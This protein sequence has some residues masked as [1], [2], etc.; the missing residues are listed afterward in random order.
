MS[1]SCVLWSWNNIE[2]GGPGGVRTLAGA[3]VY[4]ALVPG[5]SARFRVARPREHDNH[6]SASYIPKTSFAFRPVPT[7]DSTTKQ[8]R[9]GHIDKYIYYYIFTLCIHYYSIIITVLLNYYYIIITEY[10]MI[11]KTSMILFHWLNI[12]NI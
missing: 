6:R 4:R 12:Q 3:I 7:L 8:R 10:I 1:R 11:R 2:K 5:A 9:N